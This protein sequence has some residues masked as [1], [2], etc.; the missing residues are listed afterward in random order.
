MAELRNCERADEAA[1]SVLEFHLFPAYEAN[2][3][4]HMTP[5]SLLG[6]L[7]FSILLPS[8]PYRLHPNLF[9]RLCFLTRETDSILTFLNFPA[10][11]FCVSIG[12]KGAVKCPRLMCEQCSIISSLPVGLLDL[13]CSCQKGK[14]LIISATFLST[15]S[16]MEWQWLPRTV[17]VTLVPRVTGYY[18][19]ICIYNIF[20]EHQR[21][22]RHLSPYDAW[23]SQCPK[24]SGNIKMLTP[25]TSDDKLW[26]RMRWGYCCNSL[27]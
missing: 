22:P 12:S 11:F 9:L 18:Y 5:M 21:L 26:I 1:D 16:L 27:Y 24:T 4:L 19:F 6:S 3:R 2:P 17:F 8:L 15:A 10:I 7:S 13:W 25:S 23:C 14:V 20:L